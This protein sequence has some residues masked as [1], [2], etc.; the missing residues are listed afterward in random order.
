MIYVCVPAR[1]D[2]RTLG[3]L[4]WRLRTVLAQY[5]RDYCVLVHDDAST[6]AT[7]EVV[8]QYARVMPVQSLRSDVPIGTAAAWDHLLRA[9]VDAS[10]YPRRDAAV[11]LPADFR[12]AP[13]DL[14]ELLR[15]FESGA[16]IVVG[17]SAADDAQGPARWLRRVGLPWAVRWRTRQRLRDPV[18]DYRLFRLQVLRRALRDRAGRPLL[19][20]PGW[21][22]QLELLLATLPHARQV[23]DVLLPTR[24]TRR[25]RA[26]EPVAFWPTAQELWS[27]L[28]GSTDRRTQQP[29]A[30]KPHPAP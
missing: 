14:P 4:L 5:P 22:G 29:L 16:D 12:H 19:Q 28:T 24:P 15:R 2:A 11:F 23:A 6:D 10:E 1:N 9:A 26:P 13:E 21:A 8:A 17:V 30:S 27:V 25:V 18:S 20:R 3:P 7:P